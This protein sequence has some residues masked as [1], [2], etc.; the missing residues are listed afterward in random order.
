MRFFLAALRDDPQVQPVTERFLARVTNTHFLVGLPIAHIK[1]IR[2]N[3]RA[4]SQ[5]PEKF[6]PKSQVDTFEQEKSNDRG[7]VNVGVE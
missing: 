7:V 5:V 3:P 2:Y 4:G 1:R 6:G